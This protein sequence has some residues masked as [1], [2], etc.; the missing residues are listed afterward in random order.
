MHMAVSDF[1][2]GKAISYVSFFVLYIHM[3]MYILTY[4]DI[5]SVCCVRDSVCVMCSLSYVQALVCVMCG[6]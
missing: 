4:C 3:D 2:D 6:P 5:F 1:H